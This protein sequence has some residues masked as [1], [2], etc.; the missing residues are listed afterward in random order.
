MSHLALSVIRVYQVTF[1]RM[2]PPSCRFTPTCS[3]YSYEAIQSFGLMRGI[4]LTVKRLARCHPFNKGGY[5]P[6]PPR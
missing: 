4:V 6:V 1:S 2:Y 5:D 3:Q